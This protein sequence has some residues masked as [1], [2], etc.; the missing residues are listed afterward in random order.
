MRLVPGAKPGVEVSLF[1]YCFAQLRHEQKFGTKWYPRMRSN[2]ITGD[3]I[4]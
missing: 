2:V 4:E 3:K 1:K